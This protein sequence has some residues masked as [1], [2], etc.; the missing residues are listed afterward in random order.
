MYG[1]EEEK[2]SNETVVVTVSLINEETGNSLFS[3][4]CTCTPARVREIAEALDTAAD[5]MEA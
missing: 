2:R 1:L 4:V 5:K 3:F